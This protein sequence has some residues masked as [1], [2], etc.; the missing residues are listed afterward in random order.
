V[1]AITGHL[2]SCFLHS[3]FS[4]VSDRFNYPFQQTTELLPGTGHRF[5]ICNMSKKLHSYAKPVKAGRNQ[6]STLSKSATTDSQKQTFNPLLDF[7][8]GRKEEFI[9]TGEHFYTGICVELPIV[10]YGVKAAAAYC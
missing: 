7:Y 1:R 6:F 10:T 2:L 9:Q 8:F 3:C 5:V 4:L